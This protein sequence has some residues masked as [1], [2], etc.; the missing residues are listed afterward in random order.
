MAI[1]SLASLQ[2]VPMGDEKN[3]LVTVGGAKLP[4]G[5]HGGKAKGARLILSLRG[6][7]RRGNLIFSLLAV[8]AN[9]RREMGLLM[10]VVLSSPAGCTAG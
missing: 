7:K 2:L 9:G 1:S 8:C 5:V 6:A 10:L 3:G 4:C